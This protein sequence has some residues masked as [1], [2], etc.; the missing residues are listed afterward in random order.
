[1]P[2]VVTGMYSVCL[3]LKEDISLEA[4]ASRRTSR[5]LENWS[6]EFSQK[7]AHSSLTTVCPLHRYAFFS[8]CS[9][10]YP[11]L[12]IW[13]KVQNFL[14]PH[15]QLMQWH[16]FSLQ[17]SNSLQVTKYLLPTGYDTVSRVRGGFAFRTTWDYVHFIVMHSFFIVLFLIAG[18]DMVE[19]SRLSAMALAVGA[20][21][22]LF[23][24]RFKSLE[25]NQ[26]PTSLRSFV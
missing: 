7:S 10:S 16:G 1:M 2:E 5:C 6:W 23:I 8:R 15:G 21:K 19:G 11:K 24:T 25:G 13:L 17:G 12:G 18:W 4:M 3:A 22:W 9:F 26:I 14:S 20:V